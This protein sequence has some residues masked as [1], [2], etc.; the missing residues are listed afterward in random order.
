MIKSKKIYI[1]QEEKTIQVLTQFFYSF[2][3][4]TT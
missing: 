1:N 4:L 3:S 2:K